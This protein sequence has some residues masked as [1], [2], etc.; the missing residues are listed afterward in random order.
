[1]SNIASVVHRPRG[2]RRTEQLQAAR[3][4]A[5][6]ASSGTDAECKQLVAAGCLPLLA[7]LL[8]GGSSAMHGATQQVCQQPA[9]RQRWWR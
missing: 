8:R 3:V 6:L 4:A 7:D 9:P 5:R 1:M 2:A